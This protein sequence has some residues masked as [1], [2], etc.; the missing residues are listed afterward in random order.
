MTNKKYGYITVNEAKYA[1]WKWQ[2]GKPDFLSYLRPNVKNKKSHCVMSRI[3]MEEFIIH[4][5]LFKFKR[6]HLNIK[7]K[8]GDQ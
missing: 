2:R 4:R 1:Q 6:G 8:L 7:F 3:Y 5:A